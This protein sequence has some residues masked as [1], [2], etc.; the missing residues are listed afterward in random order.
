MTNNSNIATKADFQIFLTTLK[1][2]A[3]KDDL[4]KFATKDDLKKFAANKDLK[5]TEKNLRAEILKVEE[6]VENLEEGQKRIEVRLESVESGHK[7]I[8]SH[9]KEQHDEVMTAV[10]NF[11]GRVED[12]EE[13]NSLGTKQ[14]ENHEKRISKLDT[15]VQ[16]T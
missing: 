11:A 7:S 1:K 15:T 4:K 6:R 12:L 13:E 14:Y 2:F 5:K 3:T 10:S 8:L 16:S 9:M